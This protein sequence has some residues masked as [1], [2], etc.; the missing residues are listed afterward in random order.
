MNY[1]FLSWLEEQH[2]AGDKT[3]QCSSCHLIVIGVSFYLIRYC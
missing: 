1:W 3:S 2:P